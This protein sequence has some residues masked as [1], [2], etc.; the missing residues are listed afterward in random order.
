MLRCGWAR[1]QTNE[2]GL[3]SEQGLELCSAVFWVK[4][5]ALSNTWILINNLDLEKYICQGS[6]VK[7]Y[8]LH[9]ERPPFHLFNIVEGT[10]IDLLAY[11]HDCYD[12]H[13]H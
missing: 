6:Q 2:S 10:M 4:C 5:S 1:D 11:G 13:S 9:F 3:V 12:F 8:C 7:G